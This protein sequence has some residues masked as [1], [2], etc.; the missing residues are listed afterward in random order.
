LGRYQ[1][2]AD[3]MEVNSDIWW[4]MMGW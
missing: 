1:Q 3:L 4:D 2:Y